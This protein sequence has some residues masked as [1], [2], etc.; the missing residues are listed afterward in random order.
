MR[1]RRGPAT[2]TG[3]KATHVKP[4]GAHAHPGKARRR[5][6]GSQETCPRQ[7]F[8]PLEER[9]A[10]MRHTRLRSP[11]R[12][13]CFAAVAAT[14]LLSLPAAPARRRRWLSF[15]SRVRADALDP[16]TWYVTGTERV[17]RG[18]ATT[19]IPARDGPVPR[20]ERAGGCWPP[21]RDGTRSSARCARARPTSVH[22]SARS[23]SSRAT[24][25]IRMRAAA[26]LY[27]TDFVSGFS[28]PDVVALDD[29]QSV[30]W[31]YAGS[32]A[33][34][35]RSAIRWRTRARPWSSRACP[36]GMRTAGSRRGSSVTTTTARPRP[37]R[38]RR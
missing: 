32:P 25:T 38:E 31:Y 19:A 20:A 6:A 9:V 13:R 14:L 2:V 12:P 15:A 3:D 4:L 28:S 23:A 22:R 35:R 29:G 34:R 10:Q 21:R 5:G 26:S 27:W 37:R 30:L 1:N 24:A 17:K 11:A 18:L 16:G 8:Q 33:I 36:R 7:P